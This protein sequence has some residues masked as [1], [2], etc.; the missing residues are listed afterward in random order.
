MNPIVSI[1]LLMG[2]IE[3]ILMRRIESFVRTVEYCIYSICHSWRNCIPHMCS[4]YLHIIFASRKKH[5][6]IYFFLFL[7]YPEREPTVAA[8]AG[9]SR[10]TCRTYQGECT[11]YVYSSSCKQLFFGSHSLVFTFSSFL[12]ASSSALW[13]QLNRKKKKRSEN[14]AETELIIT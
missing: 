9:H 1:V 11:F 2:M 13:M 3:S 6:I 7:E 4:I 5:I 8:G 12:L 10:S 14:E